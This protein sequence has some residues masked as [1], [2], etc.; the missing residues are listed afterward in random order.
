MIF[1]VTQIFLFDKILTL[2]GL[3]Y[4]AHMDIG[5]NANGDIVF[6]ERLIHPA[7]YFGHIFKFWRGVILHLRTQGGTEHTNG[8]KCAD[9]GDVI[10]GLQ[11]VLY[12]FYPRNN[13]PG[14]T[15]LPP[16]L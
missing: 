14:N 9:T 15:P 5:R 13:F 6:D 8:R 2:R 10:N 4:K 1:I 11:G 3:Y 12:G 16:E 7:K